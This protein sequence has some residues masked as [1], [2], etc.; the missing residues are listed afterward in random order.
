[1]KTLNRRA[2]AV[3]LGLGLTAAL[4]AY[5]LHWWSTGRYLQD[6][7]DAYVGG[8]I[9]I[10]SAKVPGYVAQA[11]ADNQPVRAGDLLVK[12]DD[13]DYR[14]A[15]QRAEAD[16]AEQR[17]QL[18]NLAATRRLQD[19]L[20]QHAEA[21]LAAAQAERVRA[22]EDS[23]RYKSLAG[24]AAVSAQD[25]QQADATHKR[26][27][28]SEQQAQADLQ[29]ARQ[30]IDVIEA[31]IEQARAA[32]QQAQA[33]YRTAELNLGY[34]E[35]RA[36]VDGS[37]GN[38][39]ARLGAYAQSG[40]Q[41]LALV[42][43]QGLWVDANFKESQLARMRP[44]QPAR[45]EI[46]AL[47]GKVLHGHVASLAPATGSQFSV[48]PAENATGNF[49]KIVQR[50]PVRIALDEDD[51][52]LGLLRPGLSVVAVVDTAEAV[53]PRVADGRAP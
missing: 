51:A 14:A 42:P 20:I 52:R 25:W 44:G 6:T 26:A 10:I 12:L 17:A 40:S 16:V 35:V 43:A 39:R 28:A 45:I 7:D 49:T 5:G 38:R 48:L 8:D 34:T 53:E 23:V 36:P 18:D 11:P 21:E 19:T 31:G 37:V 41:L 13:R 3:S 29:A 2:L 1:M 33:A 30:R 47:P 32:L 50:V 46:D 15:L 4:A 9:T 22:R 27:V 24:S